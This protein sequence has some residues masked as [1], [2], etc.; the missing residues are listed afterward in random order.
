MNKSNTLL[1]VLANNQFYSF[2]SI[3][4]LARVHKGENNYVV[5]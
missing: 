2:G 3:K 4:F 5:A 1:P